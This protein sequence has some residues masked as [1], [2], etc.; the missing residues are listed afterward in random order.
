MFSAL[1]AQIAGAALLVLGLVSAILAF[2]SWPF[3]LYAPYAIIFLG[4]GTGLYL[5]GLGTRSSARADLLSSVWV[6]AA[7]V[8]GGLLVLLALYENALVHTITGGRAADITSTTVAVPLVLGAILWGLAIASE[9]VFL[10]GRRQVPWVVGKTS[11]TQPH[12]SRNGGAF[13]RDAANDEGIRGMYHDI[14]QSVR[15]LSAA[16]RPLVRQAV[17][18][19][20]GILTLVGWLVLRSIE[21]GNAPDGWSTL[22]T[23]VAGGVAILYLFAWTWIGW[24]TRVSRDLEAERVPAEPFP[25]WT[26][27]LQRTHRGVGPTAESFPGATPA[28]DLSSTLEKS[29]SLLTLGDRLERLARQSLATVFLGVLLVGSLVG[30]SLGWW[31]SYVLFGFSLSPIYFGLF[32]VNT[33]VAWLVAGVAAGLS[34]VLLRWKYRPV[35]LADRR[36]GTIEQEE[37]DLER[38]FWSRF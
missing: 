10:H 34:F 19:I 22:V 23:F 9:W 16:T 17:I 4:L 38:A 7:E 5:W 26:P 12:L 25:H 29:L 11:R 33:A 21:N 14:N 35:A 18:L 8:V 6:T 13:T 27:L 24:L 3:W 2:D 20:A 36:L 28:R 30:Y 1:V 15:N 31:I 32:T 37:I